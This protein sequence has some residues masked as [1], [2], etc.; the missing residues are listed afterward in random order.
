MMKYRLK[1]TMVMINRLMY[2]LLCMGHYT[3]ETY[4]FVI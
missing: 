2:T 4:G 1:P 3:D